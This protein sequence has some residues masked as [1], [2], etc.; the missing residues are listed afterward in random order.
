MQIPM[1]LKR[2]RK[3]FGLLMG[4][5]FFLGFCGSASAQALC[6]YNGSQ[7][8]SWRINTTALDA[9]AAAGTVL[10][11]SQSIS[12]G[13]QNMTCRGAARVT[14]YRETLTANG[15]G[16]TG[17]EWRVRRNGTNVALNGGFAASPNAASY[18]APAATWTAELVRTTGAITS[19]GGRLS[20]PTV[21]SGWTT[22][23]ASTGNPPGIGI[24]DAATAFSITNSTCTV[25]TAS[26]G[27]PLGNVA[28]SSFTAVGSTSAVSAAEN[29]TLDCRGFPSV[30]MTLQGAQAAGAPAS[31]L[32]L[33]AGTGVAQGVGVQLL[34]NR[35]T[36]LTIGTA[37]A[38][39]ASAATGN[40]NVPIA[41]RYYRTGA[42]TA[43]R[44]NASPTLR[45]DYN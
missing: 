21:N 13:G 8:F 4:L 40:M 39:S 7:V 44:A 17:V 1:S 19:A 11:T 41:A 14:G 33:T 43:G 25:S 27:I 16:V 45:F 18:V 24:R 12:V 31:V 42:V 10:A 5:F 2:Y 35:T 36:V 20:Y 37:L 26:I 30:R 22:T 6:T 28:A 3:R 15:T 32:A 9:S 34:H 38:L 23:D 29:I